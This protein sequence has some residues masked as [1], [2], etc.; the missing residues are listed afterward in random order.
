MDPLLS[1]FQPLRLGKYTSV[2][3]SSSILLPS[4]PH[5]YKLAQLP[6][7]LHVSL[8]PSHNPDYSEITAIR[9]SGFI[10]LQSET[11][12]EAQDIA[13]SAH[14][15][16]IKSGK[17]VIHFFDPANSVHDDP[18]LIEDR[19]LVKGVLDIG[20]S[21]AY[22]A[23]TESDTSLYLDD[24]RHPMIPETPVP[25]LEIQQDRPASKIGSSPSPSKGTK[26]DGSSSGSSARESSADSRPSISSA[27]SVSSVSTR[28]VSSD[29]I[30]DFLKRIWSQLN[31]ATGRNYRPFEYSGPNNAEYALF[32]FGST[33]V[34]VDEIL[35]ATSSDEFAKC[36]IITARLYRPWLATSLRD[37][38]PSSVK[39]IAVLEQIRKKTT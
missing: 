39:K 29:D 32:I 3:T 16:A 30:V 21:R 22:P 37:T 8:Q 34:F 15:L 10:F 17:G 23:V 4:I 18:I 12:Q 31:V 6:I 9:Q 27:T 5:L 1:A 14:A 20:G 26:Q 25:S 35:Q 19:E 38:I 24:G 11:L 28:P 36:G 13:L 2:T 7:V 33:G